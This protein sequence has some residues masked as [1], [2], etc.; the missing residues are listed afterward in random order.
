MSV[1]YLSLVLVFLR[2]RLQEMEYFWEINYM[3]PH[4]FVFSINII[5][6]LDLNSI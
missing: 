5:A 2:H 3:I 6:E 4:F 1:L